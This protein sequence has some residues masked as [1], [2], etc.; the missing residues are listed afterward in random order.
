M[1]M[2]TTRQCGVLRVVRGKG[3]NEIM[4]ACMHIIDNEKG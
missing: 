4:Y 2:N 3:L 1:R